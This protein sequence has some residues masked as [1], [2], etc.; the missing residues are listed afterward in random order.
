METSFRSR[1]SGW[2]TRREETLFAFDDAAGEVG[3]PIPPILSKTAGAGDEM[4][5]SSTA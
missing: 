4:Q 1:I 2:I 5:I 3:S